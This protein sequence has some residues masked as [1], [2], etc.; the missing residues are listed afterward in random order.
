[1]IILVTLMKTKNQDDSGSSFR[2]LLEYTDFSD[3][4]DLDKAFDEKF[5]LLKPE[6]A[7]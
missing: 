5:V 1:M 4:D 3:N 6:N 2:V 7:P